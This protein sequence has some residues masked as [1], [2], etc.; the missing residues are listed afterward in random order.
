MKRIILFLM[1]NLAVMVVLGITLN[2]L[3]VNRY[4]DA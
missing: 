3:G 2:L 4:M 1:T